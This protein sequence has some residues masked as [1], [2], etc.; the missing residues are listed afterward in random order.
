MPGAERLA[1]HLTWRGASPVDVG[2]VG[3][4]GTGTALDTAKGKGASEV[5]AAEKGRPSGRG[6]KTVGDMDTEARRDV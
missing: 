6:S 2:T 4:L 5:I 1:P 3:Y